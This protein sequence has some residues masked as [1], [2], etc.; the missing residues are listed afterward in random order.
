[1]A[2]KEAAES[3][4]ASPLAR[5]IALENAVDLKAVVGTGPGGRIV[6]DDLLRHLQQTATLK[7]P[8][9]AHPTPAIGLSTPIAGMRRQIF[10][11]M[12]QSVRDTAQMTI[13]AEVD[14]TEFVRLRD[15]LT[16]R[17]E[18]EGIRISYNAILLRILGLAL[19]EHLGM[20]VRVENNQ[21]IQSEAVH[22]GVAME[23]DEGLIVP[24]VRNADVRS[25]KDI[26]EVLQ[27]LFQRARNHKL[28]LDEIQGGTFTLTNLGDLGVDAFTPILNSPESGI[29]GVGRIVKKAVVSP[30]E[31]D[32]V[33]VAARMVLSL[34]FD[35]RIIN[36]APA[37]RFLRRIGEMIEDPYVLVN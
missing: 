25:F 22:I 10:E 16:R 30:A 9:A 35:H 15:S 28:L 26:E 27:D 17:Y 20:N 8:P 34:T 18:G 5:K 14:A 7:P 21:I 2:S 24:V 36:G 1:V 33:K 4:K 12:Q 31:E 32:I 37:A 11:H 3:V 19:R 13:T 23:L 6:R 29:L